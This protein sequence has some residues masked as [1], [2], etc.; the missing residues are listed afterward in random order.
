MPRTL[1]WCNTVVRMKVACIAYAAFCFGFVGS[2]GI[3]R[4]IIDYPRDGTRILFPVNVS[5]S[6]GN[7]GYGIA[8]EREFGNVYIKD[9]PTNTILAQHDPVENIS[10][11]AIPSIF[12]YSKARMWYLTIIENGITTFD[13]IP[14]RKGTTGYMYDKVSGQLFGNSGTGSFI[15]GPDK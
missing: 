11:T 14:V 12:G 2:S 4:Y 13:F 5:I 15:L 3:N 7:G 6:E 10:I 9:I 1:D 8:L